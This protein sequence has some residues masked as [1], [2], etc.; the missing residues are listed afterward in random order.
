MLLVSLK[1]GQRLNAESVELGSFTSQN[2]RLYLS[3]MGLALSLR[4]TAGFIPNE[5]S[6]AVFTV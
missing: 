4:E 2:C 6:L 3:E 5:V 1:T